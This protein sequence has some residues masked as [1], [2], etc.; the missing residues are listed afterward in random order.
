V[1]E[2]VEPLGHGEVVRGLVRSARASQLPHAL[3]LEGPEGVGKF[4]A[5]V[6]LAAALLCDR[7][8]DAP[9]GV[10]GP[11]VRVAR[12]SHADLFV[13]DRRAHGQDALTIHFV[14]ARDPRPKDG[15]QGTPIDGFLALRAEEGRGKFVVVREADRMNEEAQNAFLKMLEEPRPGV[16][17]L[18]E[19][20][21]PGALLATVRSRV[22][23]VRFDLLDVETCARV[24]ERVAPDGGDDLVRASRMAGGS[25]GLALR[26]VARA[27]PAMQRVLASTLAGETS[28]ADA[29]HELFDLD[30]DYPGKTASA[31]RRTRART[32]LDLGL[33]LLTDLERLAAGADAA[34]LQHGDAAEAVL[35][36][37][38][39][40]TSARR[41]VAEAWLS[42]REDLNLN[43]SAEA[44]VDRALAA[45]PAARGAR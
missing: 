38:L 32:I 18:L 14:T 27:A 42:A 21:A 23:P 29:A 25:P 1:P 41:R 36:G 19:S 33:E 30:G 39:G 37:P 43:L 6:W 35:G 12:D 7:A 26:L 9:C 24:L 16:H 28:A 3:L 15:Y 40:D 11:C 8:A 20:S 5:A 13:V 31:Q 10:C 45:R 44:L 17:I 22:V 34:A 4:R 2:L